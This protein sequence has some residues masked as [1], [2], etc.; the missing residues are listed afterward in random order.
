MGMT[1]SKALFRVTKLDGR[2]S[3]YPHFSHY[4]EENTRWIRAGNDP[5][6]DKNFFTLREWLWTNLGASKEFRYWKDHGAP[7]VIPAD[8]SNND[9]WCWDTEFGK[10]RIYVNEKALTLFNLKWM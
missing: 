10:Q 3:A 4:I 1:L 6:K 2:H 7:N 9:H 5:L 8:R